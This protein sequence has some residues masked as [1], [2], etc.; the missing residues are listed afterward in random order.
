MQGNGLKRYFLSQIKFL[1]LA[2]RKAR[3][4]GFTKAKYQKN[5]ETQRRTAIEALLLDLQNKFSRC[6]QAKID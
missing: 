6:I 2:N 5:T 3:L 4:K 1:P